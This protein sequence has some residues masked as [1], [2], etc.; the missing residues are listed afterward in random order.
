MAL[1]AQQRVMWSAWSKVA[2]GSGMPGVDGVTPARYG[3]KLEENLG[4]LRDQL[5][6]GGYQPQ[7]LRPA[8]ARRGSKLRHLRIPTVRDRIAQR[9]FL[10]V[11]GGRLDADQAEASFA[12]RRGRSWLGAL[13][14]AEE[15]RRL[16]LRHVFRGDVRAYF[17]S[18]DHEHLHR[19]AAMVLQDHEAAE[20][21]VAWCSVGVLTDNGMQPNLGV[22]QG[23][24]V[25]PALANLY[26]A[27][28]D[29]AI[30]GRRGRLVRYAD[31]LAVFCADD[32]TAQLAGWDVEQEL[33]TLGLLLNPDKT[34]VSSFDRGFSFLGWVFFREGGHEEAPGSSWVH[35]LSFRQ[36]GR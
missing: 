36:A 2:A 15:C 1:L 9:A 5:E 6:R 20:L 26:L 29:R 35:P 8:V 30:D 13:R 18:I 3:A 22:P 7:P 23:A 31:D 27:P 12:Y 17:D 4:R 14:Q 32:N 16:G 28:F 34:Y 19:A 11:F 24:P 25:S 21:A 10:E 33:G